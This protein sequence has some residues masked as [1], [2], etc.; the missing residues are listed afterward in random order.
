MKNPDPT[1]VTEDRNPV[2]PA[3]EKRA[4]LAKYLAGRRL[5]GPP[6]PLDV[7][8]RAPG[9]TVPL[10]LAQRQVWLHSQFAHGSSIYNEPFTIHRRGPLDIAVLERTLE[11]IIRRHEAW[12]TTFPLVDGHPVQIV[13]DAVNFRLPVNDLRGL[14]PADRDREALRLGAADASKPFDLANGPL[15]RVRLVRLDDSEYRLYVTPH[16][17]IFDGVSIYRVFLEELAILYEAFS[18]NRP[19]PL[20]ELTIQYGDFALWQ[21][22]SLEGETFREH[23]AYWKSVLGSDAPFLELQTDHPRPAL[24]TFRGVLHR[25]L[26]PRPHVESLKQLCQSSGATLFMGLLASLYSLLYRY[27]GQEDIL[28]G[29]VTAGRKLPELEKLMGLFINPVVLRATLSDTVTFRELL[30]QARDVTAG[31]LSH[32]D[33]PF[34]YLVKECQPHRDPS[35]NPFFQTMISMQPVL[36]S[37]PGWDVTVYDVNNGGSKLDLHF[38]VDER[39]EGILGRLVY[40]PDL[41]DSGTIA[42]LVAHWQTLIEVAPASPDSPVSRLPLLS[43]EERKKLV[44]EW[45][46]SNSDYPRDACIHDLFEVQAAR[47]PNQTALLAE[48]QRITYGELD[49]RA[50]QLSRWL[51]KMGITREDL[52]GV[53]LERSPEMVIALLGILKAGAAYVPLDPAYPRD[54]LAFMLEDARIR[55]LITKEKFSGVLPSNGI[56]L[57]SLDRESKAL[58][59]QSA[60]PLENTSRPADAAY[61]IYTSGSTGKP[62]GV[63]GL[64]QGAVNRFAWMWKQ[65]PFQPGEVCCQKTSL[66][67][68]D[69]VWEIFG[70]LLQGVPNVMVSDEVLTDSERLVQQ[71]AAQRVSRIVLVPSLLRVILEIYARRKPSLQRPIMWISSGEALTPELVRRF[72]Q[73][74]PGCALLNLYGSSEVSAD[75]TWHEV[76]PRRSTFRIPIGRPIANTR[77]YILDRQFQIV[78][79]GVVGEIVAG[80][81]GLARGYLHRA[82]LTDAKFVPD[83][84]ARLPEARLYRTGDLGRWLP[85]G[86]I[87]YMGRADSLVKLRGFRIELGEIEVTLSQHSAIGSV[88]IQLYGETGHERRLVAYVVP[89]NGQSLTGGELRNFLRQKLPEYMVP[90]QFIFLDSMPLLPNGKINRQALPSPEDLQ[91]FQKATPLPARDALESQLLDIWKSLLSTRSIGVRDNFFDVG[92]H[93][94]LLTSLLHEI[95]DAFGRTLSLTDLFEAATVEQLADVLRGNRS[96]SQ[97]DGILAIQPKGDKVPFFWIRGGPLFLPLARRLG[98]DRP[99]LG[100]YLPAAKA[101]GLPFHYSVP[102]LAAAFLDIIRQ[103]RPHGP[104]YL[105]GLCVNGV[106]AYEMAQQLTAQGEDVPLIVMYDSQN[107]TRYHDFSHEGRHWMFIHKLKFHLKIVS[108]MRVSDVVPYLRERVLELKR[109]CSQRKWQT[110]YNRGWRIPERRLGDLDSLIHPAATHYRPQPYGG[111]VIFFNSSEWPEGAYWD[112]QAGWQ[113]FVSELQGYRVRGAHE[114]MFNESNVPDM[115]EKLIGCINQVENSQTGLEAVNAASPA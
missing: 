26:I 18:A 54:R 47:T 90:S 62:K 17:L 48:G 35:R 114:S 88:A 20:P 41:F 53:C 42:R 9:S 99:S 95:E 40:N 5:K 10:S 25:F 112:F 12:R 31:A 60:S 59:K 51:R 7:S 46:D 58:A 103:V 29:T 115:A 61:V 87:E 2:I 80:G 11:E 32:D 50:N 69:S 77:I 4:L 30:A 64:H 68:V 75:V 72:R 66:N 39:P 70:P 55:L 34:D 92:G 44:F 89:R 67:F 82:E 98:P 108:Q 78:P 8:R 74:M 73:I 33:V 28:I 13:R 100:V 23:I 24:Q 63:V 45:N 93:S 19:S 81:D 14:A 43:E 38:I 96:A 94:L 52:V 86:I 110:Y 84:F 104:Y 76:D 57:L 106:V 113:E 21:H 83:P 36:P 79:V 101:S 111:R 27:T 37:V 6:A 105:G 16:Q 97:L 102:D 71:L 56:E 15:L 3:A 49:R 22:Q 107:P 91:S 109:T 1:S 85:D 65:Y